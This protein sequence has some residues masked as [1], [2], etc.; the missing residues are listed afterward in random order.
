[1]KR[2]NLIIMKSIVSCLMA[3]FLLNGCEYEWP[4]VAQPEEEIDQRLV[5]VWR[6]ELSDG[7][8]ERLLIFPMS[9]R[10]YLVS[11]PVG[12]TDAMFA[13]AALWREEGMTLVQLEW[14]GNAKALVPNDEPRYQYASYQMENGRLEIRLVNSSIVGGKQESAEALKAAI[15]AKR[16]DPAFYRESKTFTKV[17]GN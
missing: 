5:G 13:R 16:E 4:L 15:L 3:L 8:E 6:R 11:F 1:M 14:F 7:D 9:D 17:P 2:S 10:E 12:A